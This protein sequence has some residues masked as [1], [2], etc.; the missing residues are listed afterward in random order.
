MWLI[1]VIFLC[2]AIAIGAFLAFVAV[3]AAV[4]D[5]MENW[6]IYLSLFLIILVSTILAAIINNSIDRKNERNK[7]KEP[8]LNPDIGGPYAKYVQKIEKE[9]RKEEKGKERKKSETRFAIILGCIT[10]PAMLVW[11]FLCICVL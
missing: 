3:G 5:V 9:R 7:L 2:F 11:G 4:T 1:G 8:D 6:G 10:V